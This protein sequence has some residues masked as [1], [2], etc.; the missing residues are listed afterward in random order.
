MLALKLAHEVHQGND[1]GL[2]HGIV[3]AGAHPTHGAVALERHQAL[4]LGVGQEA[5]VQFGLGQGEGDVHPGPRLRVHRV[6]VEAGGVDGLV[7]QFRLALVDH[8]HGV[9]PAHVLEPLEDQARQVP[10]IGGRGVVHG[11]LLGV[12]LVV[13]HGRGPGDRLADE[14]LADYDQGQAG[15]AY[16]LL[17][18]GIDEPVAGDLDGTREQGGGHVRHQGL[19]ADLR[20]IG[21]LHALDGLVGGVVDEGGI[22]GQ[23]EVRLGRD[24]GEAARLGGGGDV[25]G[26]IALGLADGLLGPGAGVD[27]V[28]P[29]TAAQQV[30]RDHGELGRGPALEEQDLVVVGDVEDLAQVGLGL[31]GDGHEVLAAVAHFVTDMPLLRHSSISSWA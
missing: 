12:D 24:P 28:G 25:H 13:E 6:G 21:E 29:V 5:V 16:V 3:D 17:G 23:L 14:V 31:G 7:E 9:E 1:P 8:R 11:P 15:G 19:V 4:G 22:R 10:G 20:D 18:P 27:V 30:H 26:A 2:G